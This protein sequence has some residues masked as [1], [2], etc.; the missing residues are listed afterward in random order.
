MEE[1]IKSIADCGA[2]VLVSGGAFG[3]MAAHFIEKYKMM[4]IRLPSKFELMRFCKSTNST[5]RSTIGTPSPDE[6]GFAKVLTVQEVG[7]SNCIVLQQDASMGSISTIVLRGSTEGFMDDVERAINDAI[8]SY[9]ALCK[10]S[11][12]V[13]AGGATEMEL[14]LQVAEFG[15]KQT[16]LDQYAIVKFAEAFEVVPRT[17]AE[18]RRP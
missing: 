4:A 10:D 7:G 5:A 13:P 11:R 6:L 2:K 17:L 9:K 15:K 3:E 1:Y 12:V 16:G 14:S 18:K 8:N